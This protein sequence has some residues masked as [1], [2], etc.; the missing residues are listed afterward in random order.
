MTL[1]LAAQ[2]YQEQGGKA[3]QLGKSPQ[4][5]L[6]GGFKRKC[7][8]V[9]GKLGGGHVQ[10]SVGI[11]VDRCFYL[12]AA[13]F[14]QH[15]AGREVE[16]AD[17]EMRARAASCSMIPPP[18][19]PIQ[20]YDRQQSRSKETPALPAWAL[21]AMCNHVERVERYGM[22]SPHVDSCQPRLTAMNHLSIVGKR[23]HRE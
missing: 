22:P 20:R 12:D 2:E 7:L 4:P 17:P 18:R 8:N 15:T 1:H 6:C 11:S 9:G 21:P 5:N 3:D 13:R 10:F 16:T 14:R 19:R 23:R